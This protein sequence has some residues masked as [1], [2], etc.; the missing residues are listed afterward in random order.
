MTS[1]PRTGPYAD[2]FSALKRGELSRRQFI[3][4]ATGLGMGIGVAM[5]CANTVSAQDASP[6]AEAPAAGAGVIPD[7]GTENQERGAGGELKILQW[8]APSQLNAMVATGDKDNLAAMLVSES[9]LVRL[10]DGNLAPQLVT[11]VPSVENGLLAEDLK[12]VTYT[13][14]EG[15]VWSDGEPFTAEDVKFTW[16]WA[17]DDANGA[18]LQNVYETIESVDVVDDHTVTLHF[19]DPNPTWADS[20]SGMGTGPVIP[21]HILDGADESTVDAFRSNPIGTGPYVVESFMANDSVTYVINENY[22]DA[23]KPFFSKVILKGGGD[24]NAAARASLQT[25]EYDFAWNLAVDPDV[26]REMMK[27]DNPGELVVYGGLTIERINFNFSD[28][29]TEVDGQRSEM[30][31]PHP[32]LSDRAVR[33]AFTIGIDREKMSNSFYFGMEEEPA[34]A[35]MLSGIPAME[36][37]NTELEYNPEK[38]AQ[39]LEDAGWVLD[40]K[41]RKKDGVELKVGLYTT[42]SPVRQKIQALV[43]SNLEEIGFKIPIESVDSSIFFDSA[44]GNDQSNTHF[45]TDTNQFASGVGAPPPVSFMIRWYAGENREE[46]A[47]KSNNWAGRNIQR[48]INDEYDEIYRQARIEPDPEKAAELFIQLNDILYNDYAVLPLV[49][50][51]SKAGVSK[52]LRGENLAMSAYEFSYWNIA[53]WNLADG[54]E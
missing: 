50:Y 13:L 31:T 46:I 49:R 34:V 52:R 27:D 32:V 18:V 47:Q 20:F 43:K 5:Y 40:G 15:I 24:A 1:F 10:P 38:A 53:N 19:K 22:R 44:V 12:S 7:A 54:A 28:P 37:P 23:N 11:E 6:S 4:R 36:S 30:N 9:L 39:I 33:Q 51:G 2:L 3:E 26:L 35:N 29:D 16:E 25:G 14:K 45:Y 41:V 48:Y 8:Q 17:L 42:T 21:K